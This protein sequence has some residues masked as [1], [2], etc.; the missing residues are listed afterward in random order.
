MRE[1][2]VSLTTNQ[3]WDAIDRSIFGV[4]AFVNRDGRPRTTGVCYT[5]EGRSLYVSTA[6]ASWK[7]RH[8]AANPDMSMTVTLPKR[9][10]FMPFIKIPAATVTFRGEAEILN[11]DDVDPSVFKRLPVGSERDPEVL[12]GLAVIRIIPRG[13]FV[14]YGIAM[15]I[16][17]MRKHEA[18][19]GRAPCGTEHE[20]LS[21]V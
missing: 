11:V 6:K 3:V 19:H 9:V 20:V 4:L 15:S 12:K 16:L 5:V 8:I 2:L 13:E 10:P 21:A 17:Q 18:A 7:V 14:T 1:S